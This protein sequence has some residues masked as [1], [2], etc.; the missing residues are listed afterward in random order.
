MYFYEILE[1]VEEYKVKFSCLNCGEREF[2][3]IFSPEEIDSDKD[4]RKVKIV[5]PYCGMINIVTVNE[6]NNYRIELS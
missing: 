6:E 5:C 1:I 4:G 3:V 2:V